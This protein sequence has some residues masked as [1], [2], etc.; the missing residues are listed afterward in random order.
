[1]STSKYS[2]LTDGMVFFSRA[3]DFIGNMIAWAS[4]WGKPKKDTSSHTGWTMKWRDQLMAAEVQ[5]DGFDLDSLEKY[6]GTKNRIVAVY[7]PILSPSD[8]ERY[9]DRI[10]YCVRKDHDEPYDYAGAMSSAPWFRRWMPWLKQNKKKEFCSRKVHQV[11]EEFNFMFP[12][13][14]KTKS[15]CPEDLRQWMDSHPQ[16]YLKVAI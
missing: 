3:V 14:W 2:Q 13:E 15:P 12:I 6:N 7:L 10:A 5:Q 11:L 9:L 16:Q 4:S 1:M 8:F